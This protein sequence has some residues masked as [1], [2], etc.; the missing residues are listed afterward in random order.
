[1]NFDPK[2]ERT[3]AKVK[4]RKQ[5]EIQPEEQLEEAVSYEDLITMPHMDQSIEF[6]ISS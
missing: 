6:E 1:M 5:K 4:V 3:E 2:R